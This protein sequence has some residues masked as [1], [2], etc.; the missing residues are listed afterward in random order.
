MLW[1][2][3]VRSQVTKAR[4]AREMATFREEEEGLRWNQSA[5]ARWRRNADG[6]WSRWSY[7]GDGRWR[8]PTGEALCRSAL[9]ERMARA[10][11]DRP[12]MLQPRMV[13]AACLRDLNN[14][15][16]ATVRV[17][18]CLNEAE[19]PE[20]VGAVF[21]MAVGSNHTVD[22]LHAGGIANR[23]LF[24]VGAQQANVI[25]HELGKILV[26]ARDHDLGP[27]ARGPHGE[28]GDD[29]IGFIALDF[30]D[31]QAHRGEHGPDRR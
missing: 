21:R 4:G 27:V 18:T 6:T 7:L 3:F 14:D 24:R 28:G 25:V 26:V 2:Y 12:L 20:V 1:R 31:R 11:F 23:L 30:H 16:L 29:V 22:N 5:G 15:A 10:S 8:G 17:L 9:L 19:T 13:N